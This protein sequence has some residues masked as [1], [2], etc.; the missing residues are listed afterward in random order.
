[1]P[2]K[3]GGRSG[4]GKSSGGAKGGSGKGGVT[5]RIVS[6]D[7]GGGYRVDAPGAKRASAKEPTKA[8]AEK[9]AKEIVRN[10]GGGE[11]TTRRK[12]GRFND[13]DTVKPGRDPFPPRDTKH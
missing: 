7:P 13:S 5:R 6:R 2:S 9:R 3:G 4:G 1:M 8:A 11:V 12:D 10:L